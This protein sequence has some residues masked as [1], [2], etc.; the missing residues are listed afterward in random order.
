MVH[1]T[2]CRCVAEEFYIFLRKRK[3]L[4]SQ[5]CRATAS[6]QKEQKDHVCKAV[7]TNYL[8]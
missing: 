5:N 1:F 7:L 6:K 2:T 3:S 8:Y 4:K